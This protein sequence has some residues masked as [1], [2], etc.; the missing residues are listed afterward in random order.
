MRKL[1]SERYRTTYQHDNIDKN[2]LGHISKHRL[3]HAIISYIEAMY[4]TFIQKKAHV[5]ETYLND[6]DMIKPIQS[7]QYPQ[8]KSSTQDIKNL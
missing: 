5:Y 4:T 3:Q 1:K 2:T 7:K 8:G 6:Y